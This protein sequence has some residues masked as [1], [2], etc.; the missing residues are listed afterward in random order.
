MHPELQMALARS[1][2]TDRLRRAADDDHLRDGGLRRRRAHAAAAL[3]VPLVTIAL[4]ACGSFQVPTSSSTTTASPANVSARYA[5]SSGGAP[6]CTG[7]RT[8]QYTANNPPAGPGSASPQTHSSS[9]PVSSSGSQCLFTDAAYDL[10]PG[11]WTISLAV[12]GHAGPTCKVALHSGGNV[13][14]IATCQPN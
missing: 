5:F 14:N 6:T 1:S 11:T 7:D 13:L 2:L 12:D 9:A 10:R 8:W 4:A 3:A